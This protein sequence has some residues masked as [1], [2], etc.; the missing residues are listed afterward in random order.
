ML[1]CQVLVHCLVFQDLWVLGGGPH[2]LSLLARET[3]FS[4]KRVTRLAIFVD[5][6]VKMLNLSTVI[7]RT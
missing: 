6:E 7:L 5:Y 2:S 3:V 1:R 4:F